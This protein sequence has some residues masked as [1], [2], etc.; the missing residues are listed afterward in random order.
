MRISLIS[1][2]QNRAF[3]T[4]VTARTIHLCDGFVV[5]GLVVAVKPATSSCPYIK[6]KL[7]ELLLPLKAFLTIAL[8]LSTSV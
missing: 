4:L 7:L 8:I 2:K 3:S 5:I 1:S 6:D